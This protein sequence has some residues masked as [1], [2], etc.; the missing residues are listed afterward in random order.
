MKELKVT[1]S[2]KTTK[3][4]INELKTLDKNQQISFISWN[5]TIKRNSVEHLLKD[6]QKLYQEELR[7]L[8]NSLVMQGV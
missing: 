4:V 1:C 5:N 8:K 2:C 6:M 7:S 3:Q